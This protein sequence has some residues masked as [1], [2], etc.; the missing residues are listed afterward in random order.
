MLRPRRMGNPPLESEN[1]LPLQDLDFTANVNVPL[2][3]FSIHG[4]GGRLLL[5]IGNLI[6]HDFEIIRLLCRNEQ[7]KAATLEHTVGE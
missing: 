2:P 4:I 3:I 1:P 5:P 7:P 6:D